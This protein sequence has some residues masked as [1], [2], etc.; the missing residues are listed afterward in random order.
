MRWQAR[1][2]AALKSFGLT[3]VQFVL[4][5][6]LASAGE[7]APLTQSR[8][9]QHARTDPMMTSQVIRALEKARLVARTPHPGDARAQLVTLTSSGAEAVNRAIPVVEAA[10]RAFFAPLGDHAPEFL[11]ALRDFT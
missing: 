5:A 4:L 2:R 10:D 3:H 7:D 8:L 1:Q 9:A 6:H 11:E